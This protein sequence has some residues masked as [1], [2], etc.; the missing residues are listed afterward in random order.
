[1]PLEFLDESPTQS[2]IEFLDDPPT[3]GMEILKGDSNPATAEYIEAKLADPFYNPSLAEFKIYRDSRKDEPFWQPGKWAAIAVEAGGQV[4]TDLAKGA[5]EAPKLLLSPKELAATVAEAGA[6]GTYDLGL[7][8]HSILGNI[9]RLAEDAFGEAAYDSAELQQYVPAATLAAAKERYKENKLER[10]YDRFLIGRVLQATRQLARSGR[11]NLIGNAPVNQSVAEAA[12]YVIDPTALLSMGAMAA[13]RTGVSVLQRGAASGLQRAGQAAAAAGRG[14][15]SMANVPGRIAGR[16]VEAVTDSAEAA[17]KAEQIVSRGTLG[18]TLVSPAI[19][20]PGL[21]ETAIAVESLKRSG[22]L[23]DAAGA[24]SSAVGRSLA[25]G[26][27]RFGLLSNIAIDGAAPTWLRSA[28]NSVRRFDTA[29][30]LVGRTAEA[31]TQGALIGAGLGALSDG[32]EG[33]AAG[34][35]SGAAMGASFGNVQRLL[36]RRSNLQ[37][38]KRADIAR[39]LARKTP[40][41]IALIQGA[42]LSEDAALKMAD[43]ERLAAGVAGADAG[44]VVFRYVNDAEFKKLFGGIG[45][46]AQM[47]EGDKPHVFVNLD[48][49]GPMRSLAHETLHAL[50][51]LDGFSEARGRLNRLLFDQTAGDGTLINRGLYTAQDL[52]AFSDQYRSRLSQNA[53]SEWDALPSEQRQARIMSELRAEHFANLIDSASNR[54]LAREAFT[55]RGRVRDAMLLAESPSL[56]SKLRRGLEAAGLQFD[57]QGK[58]SELFVKNNRP[59][60]NSPEVN[61]ALRDYL[62]A[63]TALV[64]RLAVADDDAP[65]VVIRPQDLLSKGGA[66]L[67]TAFADNDIFARNSDGSVKM[68]GGLPVLLSER[69]I[70]LLQAKRVAQM[71]ESL[72][73]VLDAGETGALRKKDNGAYE[74]KFFSDK[75]IAALKALPDDVLPPSLKAKLE[76][77]NEF[78]KS[79]D[80]SQVV[81]DYNAALRNRKYSSGISSVLRM[82]V[83]LSVHISKAGNFFITTLDT[84]HF[85]RKL[86]DWRKSRPKAFDTWNGDTEAFLRDVF[87]YLDNHAKNQPG[88]TDLDPDAARAVAK[89]NLINAFFNVPQGDEVNPVRSLNR[90]GNRD[91]LIRSRRFDRINRITS[92]AGDKFPVN[93][94]LL[95]ANFLPADPAPKVEP[96]PTAE[97]SVEPKPYSKESMQS[98]FNLT[99]EQAEATDAIVKAMG[100]DES[101]IQVAKGGEAAPGALFSLKA[102]HGTPHEIGPEGFRLDKIGTGEGAQV[103][104]WG[105]YFAENR[106]VS[107]EY[108]RNVKSAT[109]APRRFLNGEELQKGSPEYHAASL[110]A[111]T[112][113]PLSQ[114]IREVEGW[115]RNAK[116]GEDVAH[117]NKVLET[118]NRATRKSDFSERQPAGN[119][120]TVELDVTPEDLLTWDKPLSEQAKA[121]KDKLLKSDQITG[122]QEDYLS[123]N[124]ARAQSL[125]WHQEPTGADLYTVIKQGVWNSHPDRFNSWSEAAA[126]TSRHLLSLGIK[127]IRYLDQGSR[128]PEITKSGGQWVAFLQSDQGIPFDTREQA[129]AFLRGKQTYNYVIFDEKAIKITHRNGRELNA[130]EARALSQEG[131]GAAE[132]SADGRALIRGLQSA[133][134]STGVHE[135]AHVARRQLFDRSLKPEERLGITDADIAITEEWAGA[136]DGVWDRPAEEKFARGFERYL[137]DGHAPTEQLRS[138]F[139]KFKEWLTD[140]YRSLVGSEI[141]VRI[142][143]EMRGVFDRLVARAELRTGKFNGRKLSAQVFNRLEEVQGRPSISAKSVIAQI[144]NQATTDFTRRIQRFDAMIPDSVGRT[145]AAQFLDRTSPDLRSVEQAAARLSNLNDASVEEIAQATMK[146]GLRGGAA[147]LAV[148]ISTK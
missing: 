35:G 27:S 114:I 14:M 51:A 86:S 126:Y 88:A 76:R 33:A 16:A 134:V 107:R 84:S 1:M 2:G 56:L 44:D 66:G 121:V 145:L 78:L 79:G 18:T 135:V 20:V 77:L 142:S 140:I 47:I 48:F 110:V 11:S 62:R 132:F 130:E 5:K 67:L 118:L 108:A 146:N 43:L 119:E 15:Q 29:I 21:T 100:L 8:G 91:N 49:K 112:S 75:Q 80:G 57:S 127:G 38:A 85:F 53:R 60:S 22:Q 9:G 128:Q 125:G 13:P 37:A 147:R 104:G 54:F 26:P 72:D 64:R 7:L 105:L 98:A 129:E 137:R 96:K 19:A 65:A 138:V 109:M 90:A 63:K 131:K 89:R 34:F 94:A 136:K 17:A 115:I 102:H 123:D 39:W 139:T 143:A 93:Y 68:I 111:T 71:L 25:I 83:P 4:L 74:G 73:K 45:K 59:V 124:A 3:R 97:Q 36:T 40:E 55:L 133:D 58:P 23:L 101:R 52:A 24:V 148:L 87:K 10:D 141:N 95:K 99:P 46:G 117:Y 92:G 42:R 12:S 116:P 30:G 32:A 61:A 81:I 6:R 31:A 82:A 69:E 41:E 144:R 106:E 122:I 70:K 28:A 120:Y 50:D 103:Y 113:Q